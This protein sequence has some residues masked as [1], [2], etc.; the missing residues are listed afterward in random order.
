MRRNISVARAILIALVTV[1]VLSLMLVAWNIF[2]ESRIEDKPSQK[3]IYNSCVEDAADNLHDVIPRLSYAD[4]RTQ[5]E[6]SPR[7]LPLKS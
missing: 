3:Q 6:N 4:A 5:A 1:V 2:L 7:C